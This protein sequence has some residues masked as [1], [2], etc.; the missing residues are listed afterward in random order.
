VYDAKACV[1]SNMAKVRRVS[2][3]FI[4]APG[5]QSANGRLYSRGEESPDAG[6]DGSRSKSGTG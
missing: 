2:V 1:L 5:I 3:F 4:E 6:G